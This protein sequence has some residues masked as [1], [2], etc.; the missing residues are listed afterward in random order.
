M[1]GCGGLPHGLEYKRIQSFIY[2]LNSSIENDDKDGLLFAG[3]MMLNP[4]Q[5]MI[6]ETGGD[7]SKVKTDVQTR[8][9]MKDAN[10]LWLPNDKTVPYTIDAELGGF[11]KPLF[12]EIKSEANQQVL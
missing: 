1:T 8:S 3:D 12:S 7:L 9:A 6:V 2:S 4:L 5:R 11:D 10:I